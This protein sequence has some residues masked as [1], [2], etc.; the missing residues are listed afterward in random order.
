MRIDL[1][2]LKVLIALCLELTTLSLMLQ[3]LCYEKEPASGFGFRATEQ[4]TYRLEKQTLRTLMT[5][6]FSAY[7]AIWRSL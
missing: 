7:N 1:G 4:A 6:P 5:S 2:N 3:A